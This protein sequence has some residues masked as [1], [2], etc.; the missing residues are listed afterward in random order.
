MA[1]WPECKALSCVFLSY[2]TSTFPKSEFKYQNKSEDSGLETYLLSTHRVKGQQPRLG[3]GDGEVFVQ[4]VVLQILHHPP[5]Q[6]FDCQVRKRGKA[7][8]RLSSSYVLQ[9][10]RAYLLTTVQY[11]S[12]LTASGLQC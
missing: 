8:L 7:S 3:R 10:Q 4:S 11:R 2:L 12:T 5:G 6:D 9:C 1:A